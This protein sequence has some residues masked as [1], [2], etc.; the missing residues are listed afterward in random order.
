MKRVKLKNG[1]VLVLEK[2]DSDSICME[3][4]FRVGSNFEKK[5]EFGISHFIEHMVFEGTKNRKAREISNEIESIGGEL[6]AAT[7]NERTFFYA[8]VLKKFFDKAL[9]VLS[10]IIV[11][12]LFEKK[13]VE[14]ERKVILDEISLINDDPKYYQWILFQRLLFKKHTAGNPVYG[15][16]EDVS[17]VSR[18]Q[19]V[20]YYKKYYNTNNLIISIS[21]SFN[22]NEIKK[23]VENAF[24]E[25]D[26]GKESRL[27]KV[28][29]PEQVKEEKI[30]KKE[31]QHSYLVIGYKTVERKHKDS[32]VL[33]VIQA[34]LGKGLSGRIYEEI[35][36]K[37]GLAYNVGVQNEANVDFGFFAVNLSSDK[38]HLEE[39]KRIILKELKLE[40][41]SKEEI[42]D[43]KSYI[44]GN[45]ILK[46]EDNKIRADNNS[47]WELV[48][49][50][51]GKDYIKKIKKVSKKDILRAAGKYFKDNYSLVVIEQK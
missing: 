11:N 19:L 34:I 30:E 9:D 20:E 21:G 45:Y 5:G 10:D 29:E 17:K 27:E 4:C 37:R 36:L 35:R 1:A 43:A 44:E 48:K 13:A 31:V 26:K 6:N 22:E 40:N 24:K 51:G 23:K 14:K 12:P 28:N 8:Y 41:L 33:D 38:K 39:C 25:L 15:T 46:E 47:F 18:K 2:R 3:V 50:K 42:D 16:R 32:Y 49:E 7:S